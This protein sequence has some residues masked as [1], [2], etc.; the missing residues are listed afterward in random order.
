MAAKVTVG[1]ASHWSYVT[2]SVVYPP[3]GSM[4]WEREMS[5]PL[6]YYG[7]FTLPLDHNADPSK[8]RLIN[9]SLSQS[10]LPKNMNIHPQIL[11][12]LLTERERKVKI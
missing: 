9:C 1:L 2:D 7:A 10:Y 12:I 6:E 11:L 5:T 4:A 3:T 8:Y